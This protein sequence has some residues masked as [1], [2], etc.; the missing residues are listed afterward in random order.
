VDAAVAVVGVLLLTA[1]PLDSGRIA[2]HGLL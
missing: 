1:F 2:M